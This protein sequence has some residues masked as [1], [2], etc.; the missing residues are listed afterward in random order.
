MGMKK[1]VVATIACVSFTRY[2]ARIV[3]CLGAH[4]QLGEGPRGRRI[5]EEIGKHA[6]CDLAAAATAVR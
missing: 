4:Q 3:R 6:G 2:T 5:L 1:S